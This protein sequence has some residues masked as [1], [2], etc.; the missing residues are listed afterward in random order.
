MAFFPISHY[1][2]YDDPI[3]RYFGDQLD[4]FNPWDDLNTAPSPTT[5]VIIPKN[6]RWVNQP[7][8]SAH[9]APHGHNANANRKPQS[10]KFRVQLNVAGFNP[11]TINTKVEGKKVVVEA[12]QEERQ[13]DGDYNIRQ[14]RKSYELP[15][16]AGRYSRRHRVQ[17]LTSSCF[18]C[19]SFGFLH[20]TQS[21]A[22]HRS[23]SP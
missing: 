10:Q 18:R 19:R 21:Y 4:F 16:Q 7:Q 1:R 12:K 17:S 13:E 22:D 11:E 6:F 15:E 14:L 9:P 2:R 3:D 23:S 8:Q 5:L 20:N